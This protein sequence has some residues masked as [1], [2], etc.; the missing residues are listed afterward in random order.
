MSIQLTS[1]ALALAL[2]SPA[3]ER[4][5]PVNLDEAGF[6]QVALLARVD[7]VDAALRELRAAIAAKRQALNGAAGSPEA[8]AALEQALVLEARLLASSGRIAEARAALAAAEPSSPSPERTALTAEL[9]RLG[10]DGTPPDDVAL[11]VV[12]DA[13]YGGNAAVLRRLGASATDAFETLARRSPHPTA[14]IA[15]ARG[16]LSWLVEVAPERGVA[17]ALEL[18]QRSGVGWKGAVAAELH[19]S[20]FKEPSDLHSTADFLQLI[21]LLAGSSELTADA[22]A[23]LGASLFRIPLRGEQ[24]E[25]LVAAG[26]TQLE[27]QLRDTKY[28]EAA[29]HWLDSSNVQLRRAAAKSVVLGTLDLALC[30]RLAADEDAKVRFAIAGA[31]H[32][33]IPAALPP[34]EESAAVWRRLLND[35]D[36][37]V[38]AA[39]YGAL[40]RQGSLPLSAGVNG[41]RPSPIPI[42]ELT[43]IIRRFETPPERDI[44]IALLSRQ[45]SGDLPILFASSRATAEE[46]VEAYMALSESPVPVLAQFAFRA[47]DSLQDD[48]D[49]AAFLRAHDWRRSSAAKSFAPVMARLRL[50]SSR[51]RIE[52]FA[53]LVSRP[54]FPRELDNEVLGKGRGI[55]LRGE[56]AKLDPA[57]LAPLLLVLLERWG[58]QQASAE[59]FYNVRWSELAGPIA[60][61]LSGMQPSLNQA[62]LGAAA[63]LAGQGAGAL[64]RRARFVDQ[65]VAAAA[66]DPSAA[67]SALDLASSVLYDDSEASLALLGEALGRATLPTEVFS[68]YSAPRSGDSGYEPTLAARVLDLMEAR[69]ASPAVEDTFGY[70]AR[71]F[72]RAMQTTPALYRPKLARIWRK[73]A[74]LRAGL[75]RS[76]AAA[77]DT[78][79]V[80][81]LR[82]EALT[83]VRSLRSGAQDWEIER[84]L[85]AVLA[86]PGEASER[87]LAELAATGVSGAVRDAIVTRLER[88]IAARELSARLERAAS[89]TNQRSSAAARLVALLDAPNSEAVRVAAI[90]GLATLGAVEHLPRLVELVGSGT[91]AE[92]TAAQEALDVLFRAAAAGRNQTEAGG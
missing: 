21:D 74:G 65:L 73:D 50:V 92:R 35:P 47:L 71:E 44:A 77:G 7:G 20:L 24:R 54:G 76:A 19:G 84:A 9:A 70:A 89:L 43:Q 63:E 1:L 69:T 29:R 51:E 46:R 14:L 31:L 45:G 62:T 25:A 16:P 40:S 91:P 12:S 80:D 11:G 86:V 38:R 10:S 79:F 66:A 55:D 5:S 67:Q 53:D 57:R 61:E 37:E 78:E 68:K 22:R 28:V 60:K 90:R 3:Q 30:E 18:A 34:S 59:L 32:Q 72:T 33:S 64:S 82:E 52:L 81:Q 41:A 6:A 88:V 23:S 15:T 39:A 17:L 26:L 8:L 56:Y 42:A 36:A 85:E 27:H 4:R 75:A 13:L 48:A 83:Q 58:Q 49:V 2:V 87:A